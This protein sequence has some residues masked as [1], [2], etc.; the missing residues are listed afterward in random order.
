VLGHPGLR[1]GGVGILILML[2]LSRYSLVY[3]LN[4]NKIISVMQQNRNHGYLGIL[5][6]FNGK[7][8]NID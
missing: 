2:P 3:Y 8:L 7:V 1:D 5:G 6:V 4:L